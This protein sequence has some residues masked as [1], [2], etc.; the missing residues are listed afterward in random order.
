MSILNRRKSARRAR[1]RHQ[2][3][4]ADASVSKKSDQTNGK[5]GLRKA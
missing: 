5:E 4:E 1:N 2:R 3:I